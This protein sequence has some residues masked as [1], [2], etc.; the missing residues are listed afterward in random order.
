MRCE[1]W[2]P[3]ASRRSSS[4]PM[5]RTGLPRCSRRSPVLKSPA[6]RPSESFARRSSRSADTRERGAHALTRS[7]GFGEPL[8]LLL[9][10]FGLRPREELLIFELARDLADL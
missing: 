2:P 3:P 8:A 9:H 6:R 1:T 4:R 7:L 5:R 10:D